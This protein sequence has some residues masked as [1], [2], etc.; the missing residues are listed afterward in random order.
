MA[1]DRD[2]GVKQS[3]MAGF[4]RKKAGKRDLRTPIVH[5]Q[6]WR[7]VFRTGKTEAQI[8]KKS[9]RRG[10]DLTHDVANSVQDVHELVNKNEQFM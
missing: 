8:I 1:R 9:E 10:Q 4:R 7:S 2:S 5:P 3:G 6:Y